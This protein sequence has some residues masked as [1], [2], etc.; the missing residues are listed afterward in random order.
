[1][2]DEKDAQTHDWACSELGLIGL[3]LS[4]DFEK[5]ESST[6]VRSM[7]NLTLHSILE[8][9]SERKIVFV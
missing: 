4:H 9:T 3:G 6:I 5:V 8:A 7:M 2:R 1:M